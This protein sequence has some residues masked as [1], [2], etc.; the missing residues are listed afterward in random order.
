MRQTEEDEVED[1]ETHID[2]ASKEKAWELCLGDEERYH[3]GE[4]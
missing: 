4:T 2:D 1:S 3:G